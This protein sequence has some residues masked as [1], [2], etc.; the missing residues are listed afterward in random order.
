MFNLILVLAWEDCT[1]IHPDLFIRNKYILGFIFCSSVYWL[2]IKCPPTRYFAPFC[3]AV[4]P[5]NISVV[6][7]TKFFKFHNGYYY[8]FNFKSLIKI[9][10]QQD[11]K[12]LCKIFFPNRFFLSNNFFLNKRTSF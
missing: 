5:S 3:L 8:L 7:F 6:L 11:F 4:I 1:T 10:I 2:I 9:V 12:V